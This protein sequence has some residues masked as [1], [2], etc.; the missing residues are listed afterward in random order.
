MSPRHKA[1]LYL[2]I[3]SLIWGIGGAVIKF[4]L[5]YF[6]TVTFLSYRFLLTSLILIPLLLILHP[7][8]FQTLSLLKPRDW[9]WFILGSLLGSSIQIGI[10]FQGFDLTTALDATLISSLTPVF[11]TIGSFWF[12]HEHITKQERTGLILAVIGSLIIILQPI[13][14]TGHLLSG[15]L[16]GNLLV[17]LANIVWM[18]YVIISKKE[19]RH[20]YTPLLLTTS[21]FFWG[22]ISIFICLLLTQSPAD[23]Y[24]NLTRAPVSAHLGVI[25][26]ALFSGA[27]AYFLYQNAQKTIETSEANIFTYLQ[28]LVTVPLAYLWLHEPITS[29]F[30]VGSLVIAGGVALSELKNK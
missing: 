5:T 23:I 19:L 9:L 13:W 29:T 14:E 8:I 16:I 30:I 10:L 17:L 18:V 26:M 7:R 1:Y 11:V 3:S 15:S 20:H 24:I 27:L 2:L 22:F 28:V 21:M 4:T 12:L 25:Y 6:N